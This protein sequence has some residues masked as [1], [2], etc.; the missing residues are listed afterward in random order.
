MLKNQPIP[1]NDEKNCDCCGRFHRKLFFMD[2]YWMG[3]T[4]ADDYTIYMRF[5]KI[6]DVVWRGWEKKYA[7]V[8]AML[9]SPTA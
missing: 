4:C 7:K 1:A 9:Q 5:P 2:G 3:N 6:T 8:Q